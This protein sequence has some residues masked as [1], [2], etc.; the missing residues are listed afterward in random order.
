MHEIPKK[1]TEFLL[2]NGHDTEKSA[3]LIRNKFNKNSLV[4]RTNQK[5]TYT[6]QMPTALYLWSLNN[7]EFEKEVQNDIGLRTISFRIDFF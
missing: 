2:E 5:I 7:F 1:F 6:K 4:G 3:I